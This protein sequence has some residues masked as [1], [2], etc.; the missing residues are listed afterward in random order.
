MFS[1]ENE[2]VAISIVN[3]LR[4]LLFKGGF[5]LAKWLSTSSQV[6]QV[7]PDEEK[8]KSVRNTIPP[9]VPLPCQRILGVSWDVKTD[10]FYVRVELPKLSC[11]KKDI[12]SATN[13]LYD[14]L[15]FLTP[16]VLNARLV[17]CETCKEKLGWDEDVQGKLLSRW[18]L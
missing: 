18:L 12:F 16:F 6:I 10:E 8:S 7:I 14:P 13:S 17:Y 11:A 5:K 15:G 4:S 1:V 9:S 3:N 2:K